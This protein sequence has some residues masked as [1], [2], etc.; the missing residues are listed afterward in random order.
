MP[1]TAQENYSAS[2]GEN[3][4][5]NYEKLKKTKT[6]MLKRNGLVIKFVELRSAKV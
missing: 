3:R 1:A 2:R 5:S 4:N 6:E